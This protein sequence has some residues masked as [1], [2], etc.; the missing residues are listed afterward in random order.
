M[1]VNSRYGL[2]TVICKT[3]KKIKEDNKYCAKQIKYNYKIKFYNL[4]KQKNLILVLIER[5]SVVLR[6]AN[7]FLQKNK[8]KYRKRCKGE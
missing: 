2:T 6:H 3:K 4:N 1:L 5:F 8:N 7:L